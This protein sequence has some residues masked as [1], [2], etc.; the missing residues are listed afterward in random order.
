MQVG[1][2]IQDTET[3]KTFLGTPKMKRIFT[4]REIEYID[5]KNSAPETVTGLWCAKEAFFKAVGAGVGI[6]QLLDIEI[7]HTLAGAPYY[8]ISSNL[9]TKHLLNTAKIALSISHTKSTAV[10]VCII[11][12]V[13]QLLG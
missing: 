11:N 2:D 8:Q 7:K 5:M 3:L 13:D 10:A 12:R 4:A 1:I 6:N 9:I